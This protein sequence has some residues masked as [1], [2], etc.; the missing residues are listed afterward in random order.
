MHVFWGAVFG[1]LVGGIGRCGECFRAVVV[2]GVDV[3]VVVEF[4]NTFV[5]VINVVVVVATIIKI[6]T[7]IIITQ[8]RHGWQVHLC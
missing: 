4:A 2:V 6:M 7:I 5:L 3:V 1:L 8:A